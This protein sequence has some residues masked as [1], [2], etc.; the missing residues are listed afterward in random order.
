MQGRSEKWCSLVKDKTAREVVTKLWTIFN[1][2]GFQKKSEQIEPQPSRW[3]ISTTSAKAYVSDTK[4]PP[5]IIVSQSLV[6]SIKTLMRKEN[7]VIREYRLREMIDGL[8]PFGVL[9]LISEGA[10]D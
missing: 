6:K 1:N 4:F 3:C 10:Y 5:I 7:K 9:S 8:W 2:F